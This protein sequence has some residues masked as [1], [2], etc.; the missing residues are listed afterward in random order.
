MEE[1]WEKKV[2]CR[3]APLCSGSPTPCGGQEALPNPRRPLPNP[4]APFPCQADPGRPGGPFVHYHTRK[5]RLLR[6]ATLPASVRWLLAS[7]AEGDPTYLPSF[8]A[9]YPAFASLEQVLE[10]LLPLWPNK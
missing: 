2:A 7:G 1:A 4:P 3:R 5:R 9:T 6:T 10:L 8:L